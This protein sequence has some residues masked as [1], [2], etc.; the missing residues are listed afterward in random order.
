MATGIAASLIGGST[1]HQIALLHQASKPSRKSIEKLQKTWRD[2]KYLIIDEVSM[3]SKKT[4]ADISEMISIGK[5]RK[6]E[7]NVTVPF[8]GI[9]V[10]LA[11]DF[12][13]IA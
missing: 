11:G 4:L 5:Q 2:V 12:V 1:L 9:N 13:A 6:D 3:V 8:G 10:I 7:N